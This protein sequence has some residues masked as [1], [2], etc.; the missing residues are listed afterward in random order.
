MSSFGIIKPIILL[1]GLSPPPNWLSGAPFSAVSVVH[2]PHLKASGWLE[3]NPSQ[4]VFP[5]PSKLALNLV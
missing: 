3:A 5:F 1:F 2:T 4:G